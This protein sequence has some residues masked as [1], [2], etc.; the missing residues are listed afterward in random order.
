MPE[1]GFDTGGPTL[2]DVG[3]RDA[4]ARR[5][6]RSRAPLP[7]ASR[8]AAATTRRS[9]RRSPGATSR[10][11]RTPWSRASISAVPGSRRAGSGRAHWRSR[12]PTSPAWAP[13]PAWCAATLCA[14]AS[15]FVEDVLEIQRGLCAAAAAAGCAVAGGDVSA[16]DGPLVIDV[17]VGGTLAAGAGAAS[18]PRASRVTSCSSPARSAG[19]LRGFA[20]SSTAATTCP[21][22]SGPGSTRSSR[23]A[24]RIAEGLQ[25]GRGGGPLRRR[26]QRRPDRRAR[27]DHARCPGAEP[28][29][30]STAF[31]SRPR[32]S[33]TSAPRGRTSHSAAARTS[34]S[35]HRAARRRRGAAAELAGRPR[36]ADG[37]RAPARRRR[38]SPSSIAREARR[39]PTP[40][41]SSRHFA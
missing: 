25:P 35:W 5:S 36:A 7:P 2:A 27:A 37:R 9:G 18:R 17:S 40:R 33:P 20:S 6:P 34:S 38:A 19:R 32:W 4:A 26:H 3:E 15:T 13:G 31:P 28:R 11:A 41:T 10:S 24:P 39:L 12:S 16:I 23:R 21:I 29:S 14:P 1:R 8:S 30:G 22:R